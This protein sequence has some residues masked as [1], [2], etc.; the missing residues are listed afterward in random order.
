MNRCLRALPLLALCLTLAA[1]AAPPKDAPLADAALAV[2]LAGNDAEV[3]QY[4][5]VELQAAEEMLQR[6]R[7]SSV[8]GDADEARH[9]AYLAL[10]RAAIARNVAVRREA[11]QRLSI[12]QGERERLQSA[13]VQR[14]AN[15][16][17]QAQGVRSAMLQRDL[18]LIEARNTQRGM[19]VIVR[20]VFFEPGSGALKPAAQR[21]VDRIVAILDHYQDRRVLIEGFS[22]SAGSPD[23]NLDLSRRR[24]E[25]LR[26]ALLQA[27]IA[28]Q[29]LEVRAYGEAHP[30][31]DNTTASGRLRNRRVEVLFS[32]AQGH[33]PPR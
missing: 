24:A 26:Q 23:A 28:P 8:R 21:T 13:A 4:A 25:A 1:Q 7:E 32:D 31:A 19:A 29:R 27:G 5:A 2:E 22:D 18:E 15:G 33:F 17:A 6:A 20:D 3:R 9:L 11:E 12:A 16:D 10:Q 14:V 30:V